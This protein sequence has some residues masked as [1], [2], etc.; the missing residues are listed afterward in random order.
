MNFDK[1]LFGA[2]IDKADT[3]SSSSGGRKELSKWIAKNTRH[4]QNSMKPW[5]F[6]GHEYQIAIVDDQN[7]HVAVQKP[8]Q[9]GCS[10]MFLRIL[11]ALAAKLSGANL[12]YVL[13][14]SQFA[15]KFSSS[16][17]DPVVQA[18]DR[19]K[20]IASRKVDSNELKQIGSCFIHMGGAQSETQAISVPANAVF[21]D[22]YSFGNPDI[23]SVY[24]SR[25]AHNAP[26]NRILY[27]FS[28]PLFPKSGISEVYES[29]T[30]SH[31]LCWHWACSSWVEVDSQRDMV[32]P[33]FD[34]PLTELSATDLLNPHSQHGDTWVKCVQCGQPISQQNLADPVYRAWVAKH[35]E[36]TVS[37][38]QV[39]PLDA[40][41]IRAPKDIV[42]DLLLYKTTARWTQYALGKP[43]EDSNGTVTESALAQAFTVPPIRPEIAHVTG[44]VAGMD[45]G[46]L[47]YL[48]HGKLVD[49]VLEIF[50]AEILKQDDHFGQSDTFVTRFSQYGCR[51]GVID[52]GPDASIVKNVQS[53]TP[54]NSVLGC[55]FVR[56]T[57]NSTLEIYTE[58]EVA[59]MLK[60]KRTACFDEFVKEFNSGRI[61]LPMG[62]HYESEIRK[63]LL[64]PKRVMSYDAVG[65]E[66]ASWVSGGADHW[67]LACI[68]AWLASKLFGEAGSLI[69][70]P[71]NTLVS[72]ARMQ[73]RVLTSA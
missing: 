10:E 60:A 14:S 53:R 52:A 61:K 70:L 31:Y 13:P 18:S 68:Y 21:R 43:F 45:Q 56:T 55:Y 46:K 54:Y 65:E 64:V 40:A 69:V 62:S 1:H 6:A 66:Q 35:P 5:S 44:A 29:G 63:H 28:T 48:V 50:N 41:A 36:R 17:I 7:P 49:G 57:R 12:I 15:A 33:G 8:S 30:K 72:S 32:I 25:L 9:V 37:S 27:D 16:R 23:L 59:G 2:L 34:R 42:G 58:D 73:R 19:L 39:D 26:E 4:P 22:E 38:Y 67:A 71:G 47:S 51:K 20:A 11:L 3:A 24:Q